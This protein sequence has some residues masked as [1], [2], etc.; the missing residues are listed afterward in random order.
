MCE[1][2]FTLDFSGFSMGL[3]SH[4]CLKKIGLLQEC[5]QIKKLNKI[6]K[7]VLT[8][9]LLHIRRRLCFLAHLN[10]SYSSGTAV[11]PDPITREKKEDEFQ[12]KGERRERKVLPF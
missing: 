8:E 12:S 6:R 5:A 10:Y 4:L 7:R 9:S 2:H 3:T 1:N 11:Q